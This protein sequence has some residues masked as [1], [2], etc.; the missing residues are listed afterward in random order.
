RGRLS[1]LGDPGAGHHLHHGRVHR[2]HPHLLY[3][4]DR[5]TRSLV[6]RLRVTRSI[7][8][9]GVEL[10]RPP[11]RLPP[12]AWSATIERLRSSARRTAIERHLWTR[13]GAF[14]ASGAF[15]QISLEV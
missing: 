6:T 12:D 2:C 7:V 9:N 13:S 15:G 5:I 4:K 11:I 8:K 3:H 1:H 14:D 10:D